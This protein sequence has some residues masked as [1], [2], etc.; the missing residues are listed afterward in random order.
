M[1]PSVLP[2]NKLIHI[3]EREPISG[4]YNAFEFSTIRTA[5]DT[6]V[7][8]QEDGNNPTPANCFIPPAAPVPCGN[9]MWVAGAD[10][11]TRSRAI[12]TGDLVT[13]VSVGN[14]SINPANSLGYAFF[15]LGTFGG[16]PNIK[17][18]NLNGNDPI[19]AN[20]VNPSG[21]FPLCSGFFNA[22]PAFSCPAPGLPTFAN[23]QAGNYQA[24][25]LIQA[26]TASPTPAS[27]SALIQAA[28]DQASPTVV[29]HI[30]D[31]VPYQFCA[32]AGCSSFT[33]G[34]Q[35]F[36]SHYGISGFA[37][38]NGN[39]PGSTEAGGSMAGATFTVQAELDYNN[40]IGVGSELLNYYQ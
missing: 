1:N 30:A 31:L 13:A 16:K 26:T 29:N 38:S 2:A 14:A 7:R 4:T 36:K 3:V 20:G 35:V 39:V 12:G 11:Y 17:Y 33:K 22:A 32:N 19:Y 21:A 10:T 6:R 15:S 23:L 9:P 27:V 5:T 25:S 18:L 40:F 28:Q 37:G 24:W 8:S 34:L